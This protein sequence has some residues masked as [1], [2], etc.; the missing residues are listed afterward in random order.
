MT[1]LGSPAK[2]RT[3]AVRVY[4]TIKDDIVA[5]R[6]SPGSMIQ[7]EDLAHHLGVS[8]TPVR[9]AL[10]RL[11]QEG[12]VKILPKRGTIVSSVSMSDVR[13]VYQMRL[14]LEP[15]AA[16]FAANSIP[17]E[18]IQRVRELHLPPVES[19]IRDRPYRGL[20]WSIARYC[21]NRRLEASL[22]SLHSDT[23]RITMA[24]DSEGLAVVQQHHLRILDALEQRDGEAAELL[25]REHITNFQRLTVSA[26]VR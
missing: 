16:R 23:A 1:T 10:R 5:L 12:L 13:E 3:Q 22:L 19:R 11:H 21:G 2:K 9:E 20:H 14:A 18:E 7:E 25:M 6:L 4:E 24:T 15:L 17:I 26:L 8:R